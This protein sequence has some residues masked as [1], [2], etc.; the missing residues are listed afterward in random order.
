[1]LENVAK[2]NT[3]CVKKI[4]KMREKVAKITQNA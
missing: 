4:V 1:M 2:I 3:K